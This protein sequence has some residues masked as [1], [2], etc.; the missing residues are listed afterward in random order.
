MR[1]ISQ[2]FLLATC[3][4]P[5][6][7]RCISSYAPK[8]LIHQEIR[9]MKLLPSFKSAQAIALAAVTIATAIAS[10]V[11]PSQ[12]FP[13]NLFPRPIFLPKPPSTPAPPVTPPPNVQPMTIT[14]I[15]RGVYV[16][17]YDMS[18]RVGINS[19]PTKS[20]GN[21]T[22]GNRFTFF[23]PPNA[24]DVQLNG[25]LFTLFSQ[26]KSFTKPSL[27]NTHNNICFTT[28]GTTFNPSS[29]N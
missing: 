15:N 23:I 25:I 19:S 6:F 12:A 14:V 16:A 13:P 29:C 24:S 2:T 3:I 17:Q 21:I 10:S 11:A 7:L 27:P 4:N 18:Y 8:P 20:S 9:S 26:T 28:T 22:A 1:S 5:N